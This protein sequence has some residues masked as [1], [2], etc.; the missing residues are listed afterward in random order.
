[1]LRKEKR[2][3]PIV[4]RANVGDHLRIRFTNL[5]APTQVNGSAVTRYA[6]VHIA[7]LELVPS[8]DLRLMSPVNDAGGIPAAGRGLIH[9]G[10]SERRAPFPHLRPCKAEAAVDIDETKPT[11]Q[12]GPIEDL[13]KQLQGLWP[14]HVLTKEETAVVIAAVTSIVGGTQPGIASDASWVGGNPSSL[15]APGETKTY[16]YDAK[17][18]GTFLLYSAADNVDVQSGGAQPIGAGQGLFGA[19]NVQPEWAEWYRSQVTR[20]DLF[21]ATLKDPVGQRDTP[22]PVASP[23]QMTVIPQMVAPQQQRTMLVD[24]QQRPV[25]T[26]R[27]PDPERHNIEDT[28]AVVIDGRLYSRL[29]QPLIDYHAIYEAGPLS[30]RPILK[31][32]K[33]VVPQ[34]RQ[35]VVATRAGEFTEEQIREA[36][37]SFDSQTGVATEVLRRRFGA[38]PANIFITNRARITAESDNAWLLTDPGRGLYLIRLVGDQG[39]GR[40]F[41]AY[42]PELHLVHSDLTAMITG[43]NA[44]RFPY[45]LD[46]PSF[47][48][49]PVLPDRRQPYREFTIIYHMAMGVVQPF[50][51]YLN[52]ITSG[53]FGTVSDTFAINYG[54]AGIGSEILASR[55]GVGPMGNPD[56]VDLKYEEFFLSSWA[57]GDPAMI[58]DVPANAPNQAVTNPDDGLRTAQQFQF[59]VDVTDADDHTITQLNLGK[60]TKTLRDA[61]EKNHVTLPPQTGPRPPVASMV[62]SGSQWVILDPYDTRNSPPPD[63][64]RYPILKTGSK[65]VNQKTVTTLSVF[66]GFP[67]S[68]DVLFYNSPSKAKATKAFYPDDP[69]NVYHSNIRDHV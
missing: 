39:A 29:G 58:V 47:F 2:P 20:D 17:A 38:A 64:S 48:S 35:P 31:M 23:F 25:R 22:A 55:L 4:L 60:I 52:P 12:A 49:N 7:G 6:G 59:T 42:I 69:S 66:K 10:R 62:V 61:F 30:G 5:L 45:D 41:E 56:A 40:W 27:V 53:P 14:T 21:A 65:T 32:L 8:Y 13:R 1:M 51:Q 3:R 16:E 19:V 28:E 54:M 44:N 50:P 9:R 24:G 34:G 63:R 36:V 68:Q 43:P 37:A 57:V 15:A 33:A 67:L 26:L 46:S 11:T 18:E